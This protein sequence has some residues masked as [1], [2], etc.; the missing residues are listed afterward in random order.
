MAHVRILSTLMII[1]TIGASSI[2][3]QL[4]VPMAHAQGLSN[5]SF[6]DDFQGSQP[7]S[8]WSTSVSQLDPSTPASAIVSNGFLNLTSSSG[9]YLNGLDINVPFTPSGSNLIATA[10]LRSDSFG[11]FH[12]ALL[13]QNGTFDQNQVAAAFELDLTGGSPADCV[14]SGS[15]IYRLGSNYGVFSC[16]PPVGTWYQIQISASNNPYSVTWSYINDTTGAV[17]SAYSMT[18]SAY[19]FS[20]IRYL[21]LGV[22]CGFPGCLS[23]YDIDW[24]T[25]YSPAPTTAGP[26]SPVPQGLVSWW[27]G[28]GNASDVQSHN[29]GILENGATFGTGVVGQGF[30]LNGVNQYVSVG[31]PSS[32]KLSGAITLAAWVQPSNK[33]PLDDGSLSSIYAVLTKWG[34]SST[35][36]AY[37]MWLHNP[38]GNIRL[39]GGIG[40]LGV[41]DGG[42]RNVGVIPVGQWSLVSESYNSTTGLNV[43]YVDGIQVGNRT[44]PGGI[45]ASDLNVLIGSEDSNLPRFF[46]GGI[47]EV[48]IYNRDLSQTE[49][50]SLFQAGS[51]GF[52]QNTGSVGGVIIPIN[53][54]VLLTVYLGSLALIVIALSFVAILK[55]QAAEKKSGRMRYHSNTGRSLPIFT[56][57]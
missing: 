54:F 51:T 6:Y 33:P 25:A 40:V 13:T 12:M 22:W 24:I 5:V 49:I 20:S 53:R 1:L 37:G 4:L 11:R 46:N 15:A 23:K 48:Q 50:Q 21:T 43:L 39:D 55:H 7:S 28:N 27:P 10:R 26:C 8:N 31:D 29:D 9:S 34:Q 36:D 57:V 41:G 56:R 2:L 35:T 18:S 52:C 3:I 14:N 30:L 38:D 42:L 17:I 44:R 32:L 45:T 16:N 19:G 47:D